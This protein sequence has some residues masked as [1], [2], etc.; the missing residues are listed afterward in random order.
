MDDEKDIAE[1]VHIQC[2]DLELRLSSVLKVE[3]MP[4]HIFS[5]CVQKVK[6]IQYHFITWF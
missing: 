2:Q 1:T 5:V 4:C 3:N 6:Q